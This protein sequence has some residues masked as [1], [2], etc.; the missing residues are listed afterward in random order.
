MKKTLV[1]TLASLALLAGSPAFGHGGHQANEVH[2]PK[3]GGIVVEQGTL[4]YELVAKPESVS[5]YVEDH[6]K[7]V[8]TA[9]ATAKLTLLNGNE[10]TEAVLSSAGENKLEATGLFRIDIGTRAV[11]VITLA[12]KPQKSVRFALK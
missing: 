1:V 10:K 11:A 12:G 9:G 7:K 6:G 4:Q 8:D 2:T 3:H 5:I